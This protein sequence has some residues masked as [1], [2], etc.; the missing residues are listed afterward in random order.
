MFFGDELWEDPL[1]AIWG[2]S[3]MLQ[4]Y[5]SHIEQKVFPIS[6]LSIPFSGLWALFCQVPQAF[7]SSGFQSAGWVGNEVPWIF[8][9]PEDHSHNHLNN[10]PLKFITKV[11]AATI[12]R[13]IFTV[14]ILKAV[15]FC[16]VFCA[17]T[18]SNGRDIAVWEQKF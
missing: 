18:E 4:H 8:N 15:L 1:A 3:S 5:L 9:T 14:V 11:I 17:N 2:K 7:L 10:N 16:F 12:Q 13:T 6:L